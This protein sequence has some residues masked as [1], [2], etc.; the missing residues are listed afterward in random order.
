VE[1]I[2]AIKLYEL[3][4]WK[5]FVRRRIWANFMANRWQ[6]GTECIVKRDVLSTYDCTR[7]LVKEACSD[8]FRVQARSRNT[9]P[10]IADPNSSQY[11]F[12]PRP[13]APPPPYNGIPQP[14]EVDLNISRPSLT[15]P[16]PRGGAAGYPSG[17]L[18]DASLSFSS[19]PYYGKIPLEYAARNTGDS[20][21]TWYTDNDGPWLPKGAVPDA[22]QEERLH[23]RG[24]PTGYRS[25]GYGPPIGTLQRNGEPSDTGSFHYGGPTSD[26]GYGT[27]PRRS[28]ESSSIRSYDLATPSLDSRSLMDRRLEGQPYNDVGSLH[29]PLESIWPSGEIVIDTSG[30][31]P[32]L[33]C[34]TCD[35]PVKTNSE[36]K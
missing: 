16:P 15:Y 19:N 20:L 12:N 27:E 8:A 24:Q 30:A 11:G 22:S 4:L 23:M 3:T 9:V 7:H 31:P 17:P 21:A 25:L 28:L 5:R 18:E 29:E 1:R 36:L 34:A 32:S 26:S 14:V 35:K 2:G 6:T 13:M 10:S 33:R